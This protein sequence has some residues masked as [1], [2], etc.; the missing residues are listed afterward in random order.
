MYPSV[1]D[2]LGFG[3]LGVH[4]TACCNWPCPTLGQL[5]L[6]SQK[7]LLLLPA[8]TTLLCKPSA[9]RQGLYCKGTRSEPNRDLSQRSVTFYI[10]TEGFWTLE[11]PGTAGVC[12]VCIP[13]ECGRETASPGSVALQPGQGLEGSACCPVPGELGRLR[14]CAGHL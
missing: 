12:R 10:L 6:F 3:Q 4:L 2:G 8:A 13:F 7:P 14:C 11:L 5:L 9:N 1:T